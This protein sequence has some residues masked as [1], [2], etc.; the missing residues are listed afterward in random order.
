M[1]WLGDSNETD[2]HS[3]AT[4]LQVTPCSILSSAAQ[5]ISS[6]PELACT[7]LGFPIQYKIKVPT[8]TFNDLETKSFKKEQ[9]WNTGPGL[10]L[11]PVQAEPGTEQCPSGDMTFPIVQ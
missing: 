8:L 9:L 1:S 11:L 10:A 3:E 7:P 6:A 2:L 5:A 4:R